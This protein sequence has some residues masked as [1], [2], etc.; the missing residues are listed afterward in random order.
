[1]S[2]TRWG[3]VLLCAASVIG[4]GGPA[5]AHASGAWEWPVGGEVTLGY[6][7]RYTSAQGIICTHGGLDVDAP[8]GATVRACAG[9]EVVFSGPVPAGEGERS[10]A[11]TVLTAD[12]LRVTY[13]PLQRGL[14]S[15]GASVC[16]GASL[17]EVAGTGDAS[18]S[19]P[20]VHLGV[21]RGETRLDP[22]AF[23]GE[24]VT[25]TEAPAAPP[26]VTPRP[27]TPDAPVAPHAPVSVPAPSPVTAPSHA[28]AGSP[29]HIGDPAPVD[30]AIPAPSPLAP[31]PSISLPSMPALVR[32]PSV[33]ET[34]RVRTA[35]VAADLASTRDLLT[36]ALGCLGLVGFAGACVWPALRRA[37][38]GSG[39]A[40]P[41]TV[42]ARDR[43]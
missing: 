27:A 31:I 15:K 17:G 14:V 42:H 5:C 32:V 37:L 24:R 35:A 1:M 26:A 21:R 20:H 43:A 7:A 36:R 16:A 39:G 40:E 18:S 25:S 3:T 34:P 29:A 11:V 6:G 10:W 12:G 19:G 30:S 23:L 9:G 28:I 41:V 22:L 33:A 4:L 38:D 13:L 8:S 2:W